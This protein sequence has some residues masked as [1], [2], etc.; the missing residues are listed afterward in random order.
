MDAPGSGQRAVILPLKINPE[1][2]CQRPRRSI[3]GL[4]AQ[5]KIHIDKIDAYAHIDK[6]LILKM[7]DYEPNP[8]GGD[9][10]KR[11]IL[12]TGAAGKTASGVAELCMERGAQVRALVRKP[13]DRSAR[14]AQLGAEVVIGD[15]MKYHD[16]KSALAG[17]DSVY[18]C[19]P[20]SDK[21]L[22][23][24][25]T[26][27]AAAA[28]QDVRFVVNMSQIIARPDAPSPTSR[29][30][31]LGERVIDN[32]RLNVAHL[33]PTFFADQ[34]VLNVKHTIINE[35]EIIRPYGRAF[36][37][38]IAT[39]DIARVAAHI[40]FDPIPHIGKSYVLTGVDRLSFP[41]I[42]EMFSDLLGRRI[43]YVDVPADKFREDMTKRNFAASLI[44][45]HI[46]ASRD[47]QGGHFD[48]TNNLVEEITGR[49]AVRFRDYI[50]S[51]I[52]K[53]RT[54]A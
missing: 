17:I 23:A 49:P 37:A 43:E 13:D 12:V 26:F 50:N 41:E 44:E 48:A 24:T 38:P 30:H 9:V 15:M 7:S 14:L 22:E 33:R 42:A 16:M 8:D 40:L 2:R 20:T 25:A 11:T 18:F 5:V 34:F 27:V 54:A 28:E 6:T 36:H 19:Y 52:E 53:F 47:Y 31:W 1:I 35:S 21:V 32:A 51:N 46:E 39:S 10:M 29:S 45:H 4:V 3:C